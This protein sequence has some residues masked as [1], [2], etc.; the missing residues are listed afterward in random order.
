MDLEKKLIN[1]FLTNPCRCFTVGLA[2]HQ[3]VSI[4]L[5]SQA[6]RLFHFW[7][8][9][10][11]M[12]CSFNFFTS[13]TTLN[14]RTLIWRLYVFFQGIWHLRDFFGPEKKSMLT[15]SKGSSLWFFSFDFWGFWTMQKLIFWPK[16]PQNN[17]K[18]WVCGQK[19][20]LENILKNYFW[21]NPCRCLTVGLA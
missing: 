16:I 4:W 1:Y 5:T 3:K 13:T 12:R 21:E 7:L 18:K 14:F 15:L 9:V 2:W 10:N 19:L 11:A 20:D 8:H 6:K 17:C